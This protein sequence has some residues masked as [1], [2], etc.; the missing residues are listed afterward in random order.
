[1]VGEGGCEGRV[2][3]LLIQLVREILQLSGILNLFTMYLLG[4]ALKSCRDGRNDGC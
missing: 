2:V 3:K 1:M 4:D